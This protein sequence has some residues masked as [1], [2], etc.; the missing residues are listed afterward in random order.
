VIGGMPPGTEIVT[1][2]SGGVCAASAQSEAVWTL[3]DWLK[4][5]AAAPAKLRHG[6]EPA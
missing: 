4:S 5:S 1:I 3:L 2:F 6:M